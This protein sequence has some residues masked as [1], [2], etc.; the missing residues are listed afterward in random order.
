MRYGLVNGQ[1]QKQI[2]TTDRG[3]LYGDGLFETMLLDKQRL[4]LWSYHYQR[5][6]DGCQR[7]GIIPP[8][9]SLLLEELKQV[10]N[11]AIADQSIIKLLVTRGEGGRGYR[12][13]ESAFVSATRI[14]Q[15]FDRPAYDE[16]LATQGI[17][18]R[19]CKT[20]LGKN[21]QLAG[22]KHLNRLEQVLARS[23]WQDLDIHEGIM[24]DGDNFVVEGTMSNL[25]LI[26]D[27][28][29]ITPSLNDNGVQGVI[30][31]LLIDNQASLP[32][33]LHIRKIKKQELYNAKEVFFTNSLIGVWPVK[34]LESHRYATVELGSR[35]GQ[36]VKAW[37]NND[38]YQM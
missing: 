17:H 5:L 6:C 2:A 18:A 27:D 16:R 24:L 7:L 4:Y 34:Q 23:E 33:P 14:I 29:I 22:M 32:L 35:L 12:A 9:E 28:A 26:L 13:P 20:T 21:T 19:I 38:I 8:Q 3:L 11:H 25:F 1:T 36:M 31:R 37:Q 15:L 30:R 10:I